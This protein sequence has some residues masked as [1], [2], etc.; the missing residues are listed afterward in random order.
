MSGLGGLGG[1]A[2][3]AGVGGL[4]GD[5]T[6]TGDVGSIPAEML[7]LY[8]EAAAGSCAGLPWQ[9]VA[10]VGTVE[11]G[12]GTSTDPGVRAGANDA[13]AEGPMQFLPPTFDRYDKPVPPGGSSPASPY[14]PVDSVYAAARMLCADGASSPSGLGT[15]L[16]DYNHSAAYVAQVLTVAR[17]YGLGPSGGSSP[18][19][20]ALQYALAQIGTPYRWGGEQAGVGFDCSGLAQ[21]AY[22]EAGVSIPRVAQ[23]QYDAGPAVPPGVPLQPGDLV[24]FGSGPAAVTH[25]GIV[26]DP[27]GTMVDAPHTGSRVRLEPFPVTE[28][29]LWGSERFVGATGPGQ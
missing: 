17:A 28:G 18:A 25:V 2:G 9:V 22:A 5:S 26:V 8:V 1:L 12:N 15:A 16:Y 6:P 3:L 29:A 7:S 11:S 19:D 4:A 13:G 21:A 14:D 24:F 27:S 20:G 23:A 10:A